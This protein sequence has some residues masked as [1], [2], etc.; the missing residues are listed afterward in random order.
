MKVYKNPGQRREK[1]LAHKHHIKK[2][3][4]IFN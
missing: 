1:Q 4:D 2:P 3:E